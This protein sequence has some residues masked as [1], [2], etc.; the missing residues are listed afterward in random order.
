MKEKPTIE[1]NP[2]E[3]M[4]HVVSI[5]ASERKRMDS[6]NWLAVCM[7]CHDRLEGNELEGMAVKRWSESHYEDKLN[8]GLK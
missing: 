1:S 5:A 7:Q 4:H 3:Q 2:S 8:E 6:N